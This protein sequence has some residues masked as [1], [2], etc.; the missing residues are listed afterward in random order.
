[1]PAATARTLLQILNS[2]ETFSRISFRDDLFR[3]LAARTLELLQG[4][5]AILYRVTQGVSGYSVV[6]LGWCVAEEDEPHW[7]EYVEQETS[8]PADPFIAECLEAG[9]TLHIAG[10]AD[11]WH[12]AC[13]LSI[14]DQAR[15]V[16]E[17]YTPYALSKPIREGMKL[18]LQC[19]E[20][21]LRQWEYANLDTLTRL[22]NRKTFDEQFDQLIVEA[23]RAQ[24]RA[25][26]RR[27]DDLQGA[28]PCWLAVVDIDHFKRIND[29]FGH[30][31]GDEVL[32]LMAQLMKNTFR[33]GDKL[34]RF[35]GEEFVVMLRNTAEDDVAKVFE[36]F[37]TA[38]EEHDFPQVGRVTVS[39]GHAR[40]D[41]ACTPAELLGRADQA[42]Y[43]AKDHGRNQVRSFDQLVGQGKLR[44]AAPGGGAAQANADTFFD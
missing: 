25:D 15:L 37:R 36:R 38:M 14:Q 7:E 12:L 20:N 24:R 29:G 42:L 17:L 26:E 32:I 8:V 2:V 43:F 10:C 3:T 22:L 9:E 34:F 44:I 40:I 4:R 13:T 16:L 21:Q 41:P 27:T 35:G 33:G 28:R 5:M 31:F 30:L 11:G 19:F 23:E 39:L 1:M 6:P 18:Y